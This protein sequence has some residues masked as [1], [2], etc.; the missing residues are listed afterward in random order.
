MAMP[1]FISHWAEHDNSMFEIGES[2]SVKTIEEVQKYIDKWRQ[3][4]ADEVNFIDHFIVTDLLICDLYHC[5][6]THE[7]KITSRFVRL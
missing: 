6:N 1:I 2:I 4:A 5:K 3:Y 7:T